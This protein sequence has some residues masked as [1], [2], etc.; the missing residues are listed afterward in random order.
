MRSP[1]G[2]INSLL[3]K[4]HSATPKHITPQKQKRLADSRHRIILYLVDPKIPSDDAPEI[5]RDYL[6]GTG[7]LQ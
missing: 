3:A 1:L 4:D 5:I 2:S 6:V 7:G